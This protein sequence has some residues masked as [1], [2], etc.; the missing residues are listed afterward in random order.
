RRD[1]VTLLLVEA[2]FF[3][4]QRC[5]RDACATAT[6]ALFF[7]HRQYAAADPCAAQILRQKQ[8][9]DIDEPEFG[10]PVESADNLA[11]RR[12]ADK[13]RERAKIVVSG[14]GAIVGDKTL[15]DHRY[16]GGMRLVDHA[17]VWFQLGLPRQRV[18]FPFFG[19]RN[20]TIKLR[21][22][23]ILDNAGTFLLR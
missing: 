23:T 2:W 3:D 1:I 4:A 8:P 18:E 19:N 17:N 22:S 6:P 21:R 15:G 7:C 14:L 10:S 11:G 13:N 9:S 16:V 20:A 12:I 5:E